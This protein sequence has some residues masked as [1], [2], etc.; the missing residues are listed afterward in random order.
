MSHEIQTVLD[1]WTAIGQT[2]AALATATARQGTVVTNTLNRPAALFMYRIE[3]GAVAPTAGAIYE[4]FLIR[5]DGLGRRTDNAGASDAAITINNAQLIGT[6]QVTANANTNFT[7][8]FDSAPLGKL[9]TEFTTA[10]RNSSGQA[11]NGTEAN[12]TKEYNLYLPVLQ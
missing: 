8:E 3:S 11:L 2:L 1:G 5:G 4:I 10:V 6:L 12:H 9:G 7:D